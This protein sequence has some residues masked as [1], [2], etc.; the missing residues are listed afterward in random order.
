MIPYMCI[1][2]MHHACSRLYGG[3]VWFKGMDEL[4]TQV[5]LADAEPQRGSKLCSARVSSQ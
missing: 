3:K 5:N 2:N 4:A 1:Y